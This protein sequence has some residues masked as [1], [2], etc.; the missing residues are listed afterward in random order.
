MSESIDTKSTETNSSNTD[1][2]A[3][4]SHGGELN[5]FA[6]YTTVSPDEILDFSVNVNPEG[7][8]EFIRG[9]LYRAMDT[10][11]RYPQS[12]SEDAQKQL[13]SYH[14][15]CESQVLVANGSNALIHAIPQALGFTKATIVAPAFS[16]YLAACENEYIE[17][18][19]IEHSPEFPLDVPQLIAGLEPDSAFFMANPS[20]PMGLSTDPSELQTLVKARPDVWFILDE[21]FIDYAPELAF[22]LSQ[23]LPRNVIILRSLT[24]F[25]GIAGVRV[26][27]ALGDTSTIDLLKK[28]TPSWS[29]NSFAL[30]VIEAI[31]ATEPE[32]D[33]EL[34]RQ[35]TYEAN[36]ENRQWLFEHLSEIENCVVVP[37]VANYL[38]FAHPQKDLFAL[39]LQ[40]YGIALRDCS[41]YI[42]LEDGG[43]YRVAVRGANE[44]QR[45]ID[46]LVQILNP[47]TASTP[48]KSKRAKSLM[49]QGLT[50]DAGKSIITSA[51]CRIF[52]Q[53]GIK[54]APFKA[55]NMALN[56]AVTPDGLEIGRAQAVQAQ[57]CKIDPDTRMNPLLL[58][59]DSD[60]GAQ[61]I[62]R[63]KAIGHREA[64]DF[65]STKATFQKMVHEAYDDLAAEYEV[66]V[67]EGAGSPG[68]VNLKEND[69]VNMAMARHAQSKVLLVG[70]I[71]RGGV[72]ASFLGTY[73]TFD[74]WEKNLVAGYLVNRFR[75]DA[76]LLAPAH[77]YLERFTG[78]SVV[79][80]VP[81]VHN[82][83]VP[84]EDSVALD[85]WAKN[86]AGADIDIALVHLPHISNFTDFAP[87]GLEPDVALRLIKRVEDFEVRGKA[88][89]L[90][91][92]PG[93]K[94]VVADLELLREQGFETYL[95][96]YVADG[97]E[98]LGVCGGLQMC[99]TS[100][101]DP[102]Q[103]E[104]LRKEVRGFDF[105]SLVT[106][107]SEEKTLRVETEVAAPFGCTIK[108]YEIHH[109]ETVV[110]DS[111]AHISTTFKRGD[112]TALGFSSKNIT[113][114]YLHGLFDDD[115]FRH[116]FCDSLREKKGYA[117]LTTRPTYDID[118]A[119]D[120][121]A[122]V[123]RDSVDMAKIYASLDIT[124]PVK[125]VQ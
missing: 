13:A 78:K 105:L 7:T 119:L 107:L 64:K 88:P 25:Y 63:G 17:V 102:H 45:L 81:F 23:E 50:S 56:S 32:G 84:D 47:D 46:A 110:H 27:Y 28:Q 86:S 49:I 71:D 73:H 67:L 61:V 95:K 103:V 83:N 94:S 39:L 85:V 120:N 41:N 35:K 15:L 36:S 53:D 34:F 66:I 91:I 112:G 101:L 76:S 109:G 31:V 40:K 11:D 44:N 12:H 2:L 33:A 9:A 54:V 74:Q 21:A 113:T 58:K 24:K 77:D 52:Q 117:A 104:S 116:A 106:T 118:K 100:I 114:T 121:L 57:A 30:R 123:V 89:D 124:P 20:N 4:N 18:S 93:S 79:G 26:G 115:T 10:I 72:Y 55:Q 3:A 69:I 37:S 87:L 22:P 122:D 125:S 6:Q 92:I 68:E 16:E 96:S 5:R 1:N 48:P 99:G 75:G 8:P 108:G 60:T 62:V 51:F 90:I 43:F 70:D 80:V 98:I 14:N 38:F 97:G 65:H 82:L 111:S 29:V 42:G 19:L 59:P